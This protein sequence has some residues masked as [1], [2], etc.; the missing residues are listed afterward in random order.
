MSELGNERVSMELSGKAIRQL[1]DRDG[2]SSEQARA[3]SE[4]QLSHIAG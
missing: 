3:A 1:P 2:S 4:F